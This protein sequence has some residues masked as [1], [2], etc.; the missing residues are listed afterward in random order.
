IDSLSYDCFGYKHSTIGS[1]ADLSA[2]DLD[3]VKE[4]FRI[5]YAPNNAVLSL[6]GD[7][8]PA[9][10]TA[11]IKQYFAD[12]ARQPNPPPPLPCEE[13]RY[14]ERREIVMDP[15]ARV[16]MLLVAYQIPPGN[17][18]EN[19]ALR[20]LG[21]IAGRGQSSRLYQSLV[22]EKQLATDIQIQTDARRGPSLMYFT[23]MLRPGVKPEDVEK[24][25]Y[26]VIAAIAKDG[27][28]SGEIDKVRMGNLRREVQARESALQLANRIGNAAVY[29][30]DPNLINTALEKYNAVTADDIKNAAGKYLVRSVRAVVLAQPEAGA[31]Q[32]AAGGQQ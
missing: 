16:P 32:E 18:P 13:D 24:A 21:D 14:G 17:T 27:V 29:F 26:D 4:F 1:M 22:K 31:A 7:F 3:D 6:V 19:Y 25:M 10:A 5:Y 23:A 20:V 30:N 8:D 28:T 11:K 2:A 9:E 12:V 15:L